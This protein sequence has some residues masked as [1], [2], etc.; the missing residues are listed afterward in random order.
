MWWSVLFF[1]LLT[2]FVSYCWVTDTWQRMAMQQIKRTSCSFR[3]VFK[4]RWQ[5]SL[6]HHHMTLSSATSR[7]LDMELGVH[8]RCVCNIKSRMTNISEF[9]FNCQHHP[10]HPSSARKNYRIYELLSL[11]GALKVRTWGSGLWVDVCRG[12]AGSGQIRRE[13]HF[14]PA[15]PLN[16]WIQQNSRNQW[17]PIMDPMEP[18]KFQNLIV[19]SGLEVRESLSSDQPTQWSQPMNPTE[20]SGI[21]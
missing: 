16:P 20:I 19:S 21:Q 3:K 1:L 14:L 2:T 9:V 13:S 6:T 11:W 5:V 7:D 18:I 4:N 8:R 12:G 15:N 17:D 10:D